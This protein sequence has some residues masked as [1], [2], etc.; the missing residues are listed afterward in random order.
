MTWEHK[1]KMRRVE[2]L[3]K[4]KWRKIK[5]LTGVKAGETFRMFETDTGEAV[6]DTLDMTTEWVALEDGKL[7][8]DGIPGV[9]V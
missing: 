1:M 6:I 4:D 5:S 7:G 3:R 8:E 2:V 9:L